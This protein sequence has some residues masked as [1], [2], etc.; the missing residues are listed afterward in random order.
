M[1]DYPDIISKICFVNIGW[2]TE[3]ERASILKYET[4]KFPAIVEKL[5][6]IEKQMEFSVTPTFD[7]NRKTS[8]QLR[9]EAGQRRRGEIE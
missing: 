3:E 2:L 4:D 6:K 7:E 1:K 9:R 8:S 5:E